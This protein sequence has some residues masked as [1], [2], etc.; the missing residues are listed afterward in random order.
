MTH[1]DSITL[2]LDLKASDLTFPLDNF[3]KEG[4][5]KL[6]GP[7]KAL[8]F[9][10]TYQP[11]Q[12]ICPACG[13]IASTR[14]VRAY[15]VSEVLLTPYAHRPC[16]LSLPKVKY[17]CT[18]YNA[19]FTESGTMISLVVKT[20]IFLDLSQ[21]EYERRC[22]C[23]FVSPTFCW[24]ILNRIPLKKVIRRLPE[25]LCF[26]EYKTTQNSDNGLAFV[27]PDVIA[28]ELFDILDS[29]KQ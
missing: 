24:K 6:T 21:D 22:T 17:D 16:V 27:Y 10:A 5:S 7:N 26:D 3:V 25:V 1:S 12:T 23:Y 19:Y 11:K 9:K 29:R 13:V 8:I 4:F 15:N 18:D 14:P 2:L 20:T 28:Y